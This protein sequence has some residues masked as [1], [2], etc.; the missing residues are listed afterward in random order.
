MIADL[1]VLQETF[2]PRGELFLHRHSELER[3][4]RSLKPVERGQ[5]GETVVLYGPSGTG[6]TTTAKAAIEQLAAEVPA[7]TTAYI[8]TWQNTTRGSV[9][10]SLVD[11]LL[12]APDIHRTSTPQEEIYQRLRDL[13]RQAVVIMDEVDQLADEGILRDLYE[14]PNVTPILIA[15]RES[16]LFSGLEPR[17]RSRLSVG[18]RIR[19]GQY[20]DQEVFDIIQKRA[21]HGLR[22]GAVNRDQLRAIA[23]AASG[24][25]RRA[26]VTL[27]LAARDAK[28]NGLMEIDDTIVQDAIEH[29]TIAVRQ[30]SISRLDRH[31][32]ILF[33][34][35]EQS[36][37]IAPSTVY[38]RYRERVRDELDEE[39]RAE[40]TLRKYLKKMQHYNLIES[41]GASQNRRYSTVTA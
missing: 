29:G 28:E 3:L 24:D 19:F 30:K 26:I 35:I 15:N 16:D 4:A 38:E 9:L 6:K 33:E 2:V 10:H 23:T 14:L 17:I 36:G 31:Q 11:D 41:S 34:I 8:D 22:K 20:S 7:V 21:E 13:D 32:R 39:P 1:T 18:F 40:R 12:T 5:A 27:R 25:A 37:N